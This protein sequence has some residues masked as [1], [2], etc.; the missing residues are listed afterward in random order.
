MVT[1]EDLFTFK[2]LNDANINLPDAN[3]FKVIPVQNAAVNFNSVLLSRY[4]NQNFFNGLNVHADDI[5]IFRPCLDLNS[6]SKICVVDKNAIGFADLKSN[7]L[8]PF[9][10]IK[11]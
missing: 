7:L 1:I 9:A 8:K 6:S 10:I 5:K 2:A 11:L 3:N 4:A